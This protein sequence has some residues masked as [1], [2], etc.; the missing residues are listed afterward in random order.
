[1]CCIHL[2]DSVIVIGN[3]DTP[4]ALYYLP[5]VRSRQAHGV[6]VCDINDYSRREGGVC[7]PW[8]GDDYWTWYIQATT[9]LDILYCAYELHLA[10]WTVR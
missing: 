9:L 5:I 4:V 7:L 2:D 8:V 1:M 10:R 6:M 3:P